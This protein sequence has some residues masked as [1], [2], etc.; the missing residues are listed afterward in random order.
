[1]FYPGWA[2]IRVKNDSTQDPISSLLRHVILLVA[3]HKNIS[4]SQANRAR[5]WE[6]CGK[7]YSRDDGRPAGI[8]SPRPENPAHVSHQS[9]NLLVSIKI[10]SRI[11]KNQWHELAIPGPLK[12]NAE[13]WPW[14]MVNVVVISI[15]SLIVIPPLFSTLVAHKYR[16]C[17]LSKWCCEIHPRNQHLS[18]RGNNKLL[19]IGMPFSLLSAHAGEEAVAAG[20][21]QTTSL[22]S[23]QNT[24]KQVLY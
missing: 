22:S 2:L 17:T 11:S 18:Y 14:W 20:W 24:N 12:A 9:S 23:P 8:E 7:K 19:Q 16:G 13:K 3:N 4:C 15:S 21:V 5:A 10:A 1:M 6:I